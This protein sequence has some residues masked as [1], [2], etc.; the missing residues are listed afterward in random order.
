[1]GEQN[2][3]ASARCGREWGSRIVMLVH[4]VRGEWGSRIVVLVHDVRD[5]WGAE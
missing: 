2:I 4:D 5:E 1:M 3:C